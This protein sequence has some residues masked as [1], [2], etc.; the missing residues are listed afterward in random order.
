MVCKKT[1]SIQYTEV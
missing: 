1:L